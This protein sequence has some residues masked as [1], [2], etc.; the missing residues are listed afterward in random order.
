M[1]IEFQA[2]PEP[3]CFVDVLNPPVTGHRGIDQE[4]IVLRRDVNQ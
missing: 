4:A 3:R 1:Q 2:I